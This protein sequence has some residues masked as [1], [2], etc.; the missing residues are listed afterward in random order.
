MVGGFAY[1][2]KVQAMVELEAV[3]ASKVDAKRKAIRQ[4]LPRQQT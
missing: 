1:C 3:E 4:Q 2:Q